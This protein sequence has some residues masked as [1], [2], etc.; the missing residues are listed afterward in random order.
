ME[1]ATTLLIAVGLAMDAFAVSISGGA[2]IREGRIQWALIIGALFGGFQAGMPVLGWLAGTALA[3]FVGTY[4]PWIAF[5]LLALI[6]GKM[7]V[8]AVRGDG[9]SVRFENGATVLLLLAIATSIDALAV[10]VSF[11]VLDTPIALPAT[12]IG[13]V[14]FAFSAAGVLL[15][16]AFGHIMGRKAGIVGGV[17]LVGIGLRILLEHLFF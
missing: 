4:G 1:F 3:S 9:E 14:T 8:E 12:T 16:S 5:L 2:A 7:I 17:I 6:G 11:A 10:G 13:I 15:G